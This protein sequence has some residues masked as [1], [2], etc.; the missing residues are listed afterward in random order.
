MNTQYHDQLKTTVNRLMEKPRGILAIDESN[1]SCN[2]RFTALG[3]QPTQENRR[4]YRELLI[5]TPDIE[6]YVSG[7]IMYDETIRQTTVD[8]WRFPDILHDKGIEIG[9]K[10]DQG[11]ELFPGSDVEQITK[12]FDGL[13]ERLIEYRDTYGASFTKWRSVVHITDVLPTDEVLI[14]NATD[15]AQYAKIVQD[16]GMVPIIEPEVL[17]NGTH[18]LERC[19]EV[20]RHNL[21][22]LFHAMQIA[23][24][25]LPGLILKTSMVIS[26]DRALLQAT[27]DE[28]ARATVKC[29]TETVPT[30]IGGIVFLSGGQD[31]L[32]ASIHL[33]MMSDISNLPWPLTFSYSRAIQNDT[34]Q[35]FAHNPLNITAAQDKLLYWANMNSRATRGELS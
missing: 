27:P 3:I 24:V 19:Y 35:S 5:T 9:I 10:V 32:H 8:G 26:G 23:E 4:L 20:T 2:K 30:D 1:D 6:Q 29:L 22:I 7:Y 16:A 28:V 12:G 31:Q 13:P 15:L 21:E 17:I 33:S 11:L 18:T 25:Y 14:R 34:L